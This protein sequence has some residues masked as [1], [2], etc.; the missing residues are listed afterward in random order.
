MTDKLF[1]AGCSHTEGFEITETDKLHDADLEL[2]WSGVL[3]KK[4]K[5]KQKILPVEHLHK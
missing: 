3:A 4:L 2:R 1:V 5:R